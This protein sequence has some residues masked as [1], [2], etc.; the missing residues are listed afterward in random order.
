MTLLLP[1]CTLAALWIGVHLGTWEERRR[2]ALRGL[3]REER[4]ETHRFARAVAPSLR[5][6][7]GWEVRRLH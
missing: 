2:R 5:T 3:V 4:D 1:L 6:P 7:V